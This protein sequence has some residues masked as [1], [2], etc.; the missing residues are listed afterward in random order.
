[1]QFV[2]VLGVTVVI[3]AL[4]AMLDGVGAPERSA[5][6]L[7]TG[8]A[9]FFG[10]LLM[11]GARAGDRFGH[12]RAVLAG[13]AAFA[14][15]SLLAAPAGSVAVLVAARCLQ[16]AGAAISVP[17]PCGCWP[18]SAAWRPTSSAGARSTG[19]T[20]RSPPCSRCSSCAPC[21]RARVTAASGSTPA[22]R[23]CSP[24]G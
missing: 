2:D 4:P 14:A 9:M 22:A 7:V 1:V 18:S 24:P 19:P 20:C 10:G 11:L 17:G 12:R 6:L 15:G 3:T 16:G 5:T 8:Y 21:R 13:L 23:S